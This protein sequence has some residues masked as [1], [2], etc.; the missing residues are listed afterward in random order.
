VQEAAETDPNLRV[1]IDRWPHLPEHIRGTIRTLV[2]STR[3]R[4]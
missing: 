1:V 3:P 2:E 4:R